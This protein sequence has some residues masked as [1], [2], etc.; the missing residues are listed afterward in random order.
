MKTL[1]TALPCVLAASNPR[2]QVA[3]A[4]I[5]AGRARALLYSESL[6]L[7][8]W[9]SLQAFLC[10]PLVQARFWQVAEQ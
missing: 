3:M 8:C 10:P 7:I 6:L 5:S 2:F 4:C 1:P 9:M